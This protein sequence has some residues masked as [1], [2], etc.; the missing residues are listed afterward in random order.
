MKNQRN[1]K[2]L[3]PPRAKKLKTNIVREGEHTGHAHRFEA[4]TATLF[5][6]G[7]NLFM[8]VP[9]VAPVT[10]EEHNKIDVLSGEYRIEG[11]REFDH[12]LEEARDVLD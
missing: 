12:F 3:I 7:E 11:V 6:M 5:G 1:K 9:N 2:T 10:H 4:G 8:K